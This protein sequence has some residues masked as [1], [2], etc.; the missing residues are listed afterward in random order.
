MDETAESL[1]DMAMF[2]LK[3]VQE[4]PEKER[5]GLKNFTIEVPVYLQRELHRIRRVFAEAMI[6]FSLEETHQ[7]SGQTHEIKIFL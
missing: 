7:I 1:R 6:D 3:K 4:I 2:L 5:R